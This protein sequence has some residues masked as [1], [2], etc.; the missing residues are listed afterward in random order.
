MVATTDQKAR[1]LDL[2]RNL[3]DMSLD[4]NRDICHI[5]DVLQI[6]KDDRD[7]AQ[8]LLAKQQSIPWWS[9]WKTYPVGGKIRDQLILEIEQDEKKI[10]DWARS[11]M[12]HKD[13]KTSPK[14]QSV[15]FVLASPQDLGFTK[16]T[17]TDELYAR[18]KVLGLDLCEA[19]DGLTIRKLYS[20]Q[21]DGEV[22]WIAMK[23]IT[24]SDGHPYVFGLG[25]V[26]GS[27]WLSG[28]LARPSGQWDLDDRVVFRLS[29]SSSSPPKAD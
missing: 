20:D 4:G 26:G 7:F 22:I 12:M 2:T 15:D 14:A 17:T 23:Q 6:I 3:W 8:R 28:R 29:K 9:I 16:M 25:R 18:A 27:V 19:E 1:L 10:G 24:D 21:P 13:F 5:L 11:M